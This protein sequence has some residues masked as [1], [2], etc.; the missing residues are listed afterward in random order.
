MLKL[1]EYLQRAAKCREL[2]GQTASLHDR[3][4][5]EKM[6]VTHF[7]R[8]YSTQDGFGL[9]PIRTPNMS[10]LGQKADT[11]AAKRHVRFTSESGHVQ[12][13][14]R[15]PLRANSGHASIFGVNWKNPPSARP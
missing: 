7:P 14:H 13:K 2:V 9:R 12:R 11:C 4:E 15:C 6:A 10:A 8:N 3:A 1:T 5:L